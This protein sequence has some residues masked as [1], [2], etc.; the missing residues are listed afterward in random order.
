MCTCVCVCV[1]VHVHVCVCARVLGLWADKYQG[2][3]KGPLFDC[4]SNPL[5]SLSP[6]LS[7]SQSGMEPRILYKL[8]KHSVTGLPPIPSLY[9]YII[10]VLL[11]L[12]S[13]LAVGKL[14][15]TALAR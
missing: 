11:K 8:G 13:D 5:L 10:R 3:I 1:C 15:Y 7:L 4:I 6:S 2:V 14:D 12:K 9:F